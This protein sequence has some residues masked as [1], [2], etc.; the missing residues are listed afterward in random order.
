MTNWKE[1]IEANW[2][3]VVE[4]MQKA[5]H[6]VGEGDGGSVLRVELS[7]DGKLETYWTFENITSPEVRDGKAIVIGTYYGGDVW[8]EEWA[9]TYDA[10]FGLEMLLEHL[11][12]W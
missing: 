10:T 4:A 8:T 7:E 11:Q 3:A 12:G 1:I 9:D 6:D 2:D 5:A